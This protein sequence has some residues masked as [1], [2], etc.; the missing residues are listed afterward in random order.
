MTPRSTQRITSSADREKL[1]AAL[2]ALCG[3]AARWGTEFNI[4]K[5]K[6]MHIGNNNPE[7]QFNMGGQPLA[8]TTED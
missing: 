3:W 8:A 6:T 5:C 4:P 7:Y 2:D 1:H